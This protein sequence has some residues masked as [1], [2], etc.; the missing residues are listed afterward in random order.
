MSRLKKAF[1]KL[2]DVCI[3]CG[4]PTNGKYLIGD[5]DYCGDD[6]QQ[7][8]EKPENERKIKRTEEAKKLLKDITGDL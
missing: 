4:T 1:N 8:I 6:Y 5:N 3:V 2:Q 7:E